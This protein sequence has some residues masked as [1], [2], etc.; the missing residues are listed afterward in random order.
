MHI[1]EAVLQDTAGLNYIF[2]RCRFE[3]AEVVS[4]FVLFCIDPRGFEL[5]L[6]FLPGALSNGSLTKVMEVKESLLNSSL[7]DV[8]R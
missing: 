7:T 8:S 3:V 5:L 1:V 2:Y 4:C 6:E